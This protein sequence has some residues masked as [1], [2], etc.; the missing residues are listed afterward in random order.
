MYKIRIEN[1]RLRTIEATYT[2]TDIT[3]FGYASTCT[4]KANSTP[5]SRLKCTPVD[6][7]ASSNVSTS[8]KAEWRGNPHTYNVIKYY[9][10][11]GC[12]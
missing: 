5:D 7:K 9:D 1:Y 11:E 12:F 3:V 10:F 6:A 8:V 2:Q 4:A